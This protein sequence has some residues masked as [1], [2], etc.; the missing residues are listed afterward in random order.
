MGFSYFVLE[1]LLRN[2]K[3]FIYVKT[4]ENWFVCM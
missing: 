4:S 2:T 1:V 3:M